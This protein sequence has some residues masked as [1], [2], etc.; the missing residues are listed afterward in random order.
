MRLSDTDNEDAAATG[1]RL[2]L[3]ALRAL[4]RKEHGARELQRKLEKKGFP[5]EQVSQVLTSLQR[6]GL[7]NDNRYAA[8]FVR[9]HVLRGQG[10]CRIRAELR[11]HGLAA[12]AIEQALAAADVDWQQLA[13]EVRRKRFGANPPRTAPERAKQGRFL[14]YRGFDSDQIRAAFRGVTASEELTEYSADEARDPRDLDTD[15]S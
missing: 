4:T 1:K 6:E 3:V 9:Q 11:T 14:Q 13:R 5:A 2:R 12:E 7:L 15:G 10:P 8:S